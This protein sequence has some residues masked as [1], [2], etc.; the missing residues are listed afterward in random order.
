MSKNVIDLSTVTLP[1]PKEYWTTIKD[2]RNSVPCGLQTRES[3]KE[4]ELKML[5]R[6]LIGT[7]N[8]PGSWLSSEFIHAERDGDTLKHY[9]HTRFKLLVQAA[10]DG[11]IDMS[12]PVQVREYAG[13]LSDE[14]R[15]VLYQ[16]AKT[17]IAPTQTNSVQHDVADAW[18]IF[19][20]CPSDYLIDKR[21]A[22]RLSARAN[23]MERN[24]SHNRRDAAFAI[25]RACYMLSLEPAEL[26][27]IGEYQQRKYLGKDAEGKDKW[28]QTAA[29]VNAELDKFAN[30]LQDKETTI[31]YVQGCFG[32]PAGQTAPTRT[33]D[34]AKVD[35]ESIAKNAPNATVRTICAS[36]SKGKMPEFPTDVNL[37]LEAIATAT[38]KEHADM[39]HVCRAK[40]GRLFPAP[41]KEKE[42]VSARRK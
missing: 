14:Q 2:I 6:S 26:F 41:K 9:N 10:S 8:A 19:S 20:L 5:E 21:G 36:L 18:R 1:S 42:T 24:G 13:P 32:V 28:Q 40:C 34:K 25:C 30:K 39:L 11:K 23:I 29:G 31:K 35:L 38:S 22:S 17:A 7:H 15:H 4:N 27:K 16:R 3:T 12:Y 33:S 37:L